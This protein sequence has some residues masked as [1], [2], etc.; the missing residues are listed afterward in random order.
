MTSLDSS[1][2]GESAVQYELPTNARKETTV[3]VPLTGNTSI[4]TP[5][6]V[7][8][9][10]TATCNQNS[11][12]APATVYDTP[13]TRASTVY[14]ATEPIRTITTTLPMGKHINTQDRASTNSDISLDLMSLRGV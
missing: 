5:T 7:V 9:L 10:D 3:G 13:P 6:A 14:T 2:S 4:I 1:R 8:S 12:N 11:A